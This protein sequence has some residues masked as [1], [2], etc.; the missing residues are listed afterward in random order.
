MA[1]Q[2]PPPVPQVTEELLKYLEVTFPDRCPSI[3]DP[4][5]TIWVAVGGRKVVEHLKGLY[6]IQ[7]GITQAPASGDNF[8]TTQA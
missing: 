2:P 4:D 8:I 1:T 3:G 5:R 7:N 6:D